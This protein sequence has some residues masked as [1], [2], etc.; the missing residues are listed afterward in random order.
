MSRNQQKPGQLH[1][2]IVSGSTGHHAAIKALEHIVL[3]AVLISAATMME[4][5]THHEQIFIVI[6]TDQHVLPATVWNPGCPAN[7]G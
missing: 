1:T 7:S 4:V 5:W 3:P 2:S 6:V